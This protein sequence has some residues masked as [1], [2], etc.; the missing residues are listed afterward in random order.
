MKNSTKGACKVKFIPLAV[1]SLILLAAC[2][3]G[4]IP[5]LMPTSTPRSAPTGPPALA[6]TEQATATKIATPTARTRSTPTPRPNSSI[7]QILEPAGAKVPAF[8]HVYLIVMENKELGDIVGSASAHYI[9]DLID[10]YGLATNFTAVAHPSQPNYVALFSGST[11]GIKDDKQ[12]TV[13]A[14]NL[15]DQ[16][17]A[18]GK[19]W[20][21]Y[22]QN[23]PSAC[24]TGM[25]ASGGKD[26]DGK[27]LRRHNPA[28]S[29]SNISGSASRC[30]NIVDFSR[31]DPAAADFEMII[32][33]AC[34]DMHDCSIEQGDQ[35]LQQFVP[36]IVDSD[37]WK[38]GGVLFITWDE[39][40][41]NK[42]GGG[43]VP[44]IVISPRVPGGLQSSAP[45]N[46]Y[47]LL[48]TIQDAWGLGCLGQT[49]SANNLGEFFH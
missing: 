24:F 18:K 29:F 31:F 40:T 37:A 32:A 10:H 13:S 21:M 49:C 45:H 4:A 1:L 7:N 28:I 38:S 14:T 47:S 27:Y 16:L 3:P 39:G 41:T 34:N 43:Q 33:N 12:H 17:E 44:T 20:K 6:P 19:T 23:F 30:A 48:R 35:F 11:Q 22:Q 36:T 42:G 25:T 15:A 46:H 2:A 26:G 9:N 5:T 8:T